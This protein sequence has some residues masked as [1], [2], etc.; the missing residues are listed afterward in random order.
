MSMPSST[1]P[2][3]WDLETPG[4]D[5]QT[6]SSSDYARKCRDLMALNK[7]LKELGAE[8]IFDLPR[9]VVI[10]GQSSGKSSLVEALSGINVPRDSGTCTR[11]PMVC[12]MSS[13][14]T[15]WYCSIAIE[16]GDNHGVPNETPT[17]FGPTIIDNK[18]AMEIWIRRA[19]AAVLS[20]HR[21]PDYFLTMSD[22]ELRDNARNDTDICPFSKNA[23][24]VD[25]HD[26]YATDLSFVDLP[27][28]IQNA[29]PD[30]IQTIRSLV[31]YY[32]TGS[33]TLIVIAMPMN[34][35]I[36][37]MEAMV[38][39][40]RADPEKERT[41]GVLTKPDTLTRGA[42]GVREKWKAVLEGRERPTKHGYYCVRLPDDEER[43]RQITPSE[44]QQ[45]DAFFFHTTAPWNRMADRSRFG[46]SN[47]MSN[48]SA[49]LVERI[50]NNLPELRNAVQ[51]ELAECSRAV[52][53]LPPV[54]DVEPSAEIIRRINE[55]CKD[56]S[57]A[58]GGDRPNKVFIQKN[59]ARYL[60][61]KS[62][63]VETAPDFRPFTNRTEGLGENLTFSNSEPRWLSDIRRVVKQSI[64]WELPG[65]IPFEATT[66]LIRQY[67]A[68]WEE[69]S[70]SCFND[71]AK[72]LNILVKDLLHQHFGQYKELEKYTSDLTYK[73]RDTCI[74]A[75]LSNVKRILVFEKYTLFTQNFEDVSLEQRK[76]QDKYEQ[77][78][79][80]WLIQPRVVSTAVPQPL[81]T[82]PPTRLDP[83]LEFAPPTW[84][85]D[86]EIQIIAKVQA[87]FQI[88][89]KRIIDY[90]PLT[91]EHELN[92]NF[93]QAIA[94]TLLGRL[95]KDSG[96]GH[97]DLASLLSEDPVLERKRKFLKEKEGRLMRIEV[98]LENFRSI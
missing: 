19:Q 69:P 95:F 63:I 70:I 25:V 6:I 83:E 17:P 75:A 34:D 81:Y 7:D 1:H 30:L 84:S 24:H 38:L 67:T 47:F 85:I 55:F 52:S 74:H 31:E 43:K 65:E 62:D 11:C 35:D 59:K 3:F 44:A 13:N 56:V 94:K 68:L 53:L 28:L 16:C 89:Y 73:E 61:Y 51:A 2:A 58:V 82:F 72:N 41:I 33:N 92:Q 96:G 90:V 98:K 9:I 32:I 21:S 46:I 15:S 20:P 80:N 60:R 48:I 76:W 26:P 79:K 39:A 91:I 5:A 78:R 10:G 42:T 45:N 93:A 29:E 71:V 18:D 49:L 50:E 37:M 4:S 97:L 87:Y 88:A 40:G 12:T 22:A 36:E 57:E 64:G 66:F 23:V 77:Y 54:L 86:E 27:G 8:T 14:T